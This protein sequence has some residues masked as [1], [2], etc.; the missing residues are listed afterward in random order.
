MHAHLSAK[1]SMEELESC[2]S[3]KKKILYLIY[4]ARTNSC[5]FLMATENSCLWV[6]GWDLSGNQRLQYN[7]LHAVQ[8]AITDKN[9]LTNSTP[10]TPAPIKIIFSGTLFRDKAPVDDI[11]TF[12]STCRETTKWKLK[13]YFC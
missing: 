5:Q 9:V 6:C 8:I 7:V 4:L 12:S 13:I 11:I 3:Y 10:I 1:C 2:K